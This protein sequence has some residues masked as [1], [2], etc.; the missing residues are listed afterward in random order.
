MA[1]DHDDAGAVV[2]GGQ[3]SFV[4]GAA[5]IEV[6]RITAL[7]AGEREQSD[8]AVAGYVEY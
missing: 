2:Y 3:G 4:D 1:G 5:Q 7:I 8:F 6:Q